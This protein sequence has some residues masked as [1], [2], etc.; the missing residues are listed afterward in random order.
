MSKQNYITDPEL[1]H[2]PIKEVGYFKRRMRVHQ[3][4]WRAKKLHLDDSGPYDGQRSNASVLTEKDGECGK[5]FI[6]CRI[7]QFALKASGQK[8]ER[9][10]NTRNMLSS[11]P[12]AFNLFGPLQ[13]DP[14]LARRLLDPVLPGGVTRAKV[15]IE[16][17][18]SPKGDYLGDGTSLD[19]LIDYDDR[20][21][22]RNL[23]AVEVK[24]TEPF[25][26]ASKAK[27][28]DRPEYREV[29]HRIG[30]WLGVDDEKSALKQTAGWQLWRN[31]MLI[32]LMKE[33]INNSGATQKPVKNT[34]LWVIHHEQDENCVPSMQRYA[35]CL[36]DPDARFRADNLS[37][38]CSVWR[39]HVETSEDSAWLACFH[40]RYVDLSGSEPD[41]DRILSA[42]GKR[43]RKISQ[44]LRRIKSMWLS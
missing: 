20:T 44:P 7:A 2:F 28:P 3:A 35:D 19:V 11:Q 16:H 8:V 18:P 23:V 17:T 29:A 12:M 37:D 42:F 36:Q 4:W 13:L 40:E 26:T 9:F 24:L 21:N 6:D 27:R 14:K 31:H 15:E 34:Y 33:H 41:F 39:K 10:R 5:N 1:G 32:E 30:L 38:I 22:Q 25:S 43:R